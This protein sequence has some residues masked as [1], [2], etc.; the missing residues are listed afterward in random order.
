MRVES[1]DGSLIVTTTA[2]EMAAGAQALKIEIPSLAGQLGVVALSTTATFPFRSILLAYM[3]AVSDDEWGN[4]SGIYGVIVYISEYRTC[5]VHKLARYL[6]WTTSS[7]VHLPCAHCKCAP[8]FVEDLNVLLKDEINTRR[9][10]AFDLRVFF[11]LYSE[12]LAP[13]IALG[14]GLAG[15]WARNILSDKWCITLL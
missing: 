3:D 4:S 2:V 11:P 13:C 8:E 7:Q 15:F 9:Y 6:V 12:L 10:K 1:G 5:Q 14:V